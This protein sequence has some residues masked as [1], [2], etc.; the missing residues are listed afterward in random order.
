MSTDVTC[1][2]LREVGAELAL[3][4]LPGQERCGAIAHLD[5]C[6]DCREYIEQLTLV[7]DGLI[8]LLPG[9]EPP[10]GFETRVTQA[11]AQAASAHE[12][13]GSARQSGI[14]RTGRRGRLQLRAASAVAALVLAVGF[15]GWAAGTA[16]EGVMAGSSQ[17]ADDETGLLEAGL[18]SAHGRPTGDVYAHPGSPGWIYMS[19]NLA[20]AGAPYNG[21]VSC[22][23]ER[24]DGTLV[25]VGSFPLHQGYGFWGGP[26]AVD[27]S[28][29]TGARLTSSDGTVLATAHFG[30]PSLA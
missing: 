2:R 27:P 3:G 29:L 23:L 7:G 26:A 19:V 21:T 20:V 30:A 1:E 12:G 10:V 22:Q 16:I 13:R 6:A 17:S 15:G 28:A 5:R 4:V 9:S 24:S 14:P 11:L 8:G 18:T 25:R